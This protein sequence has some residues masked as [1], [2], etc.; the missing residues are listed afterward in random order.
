MEWPIPCSSGPISWLAAGAAVVLGQEGAAVGAPGASRRL[1]LRAEV[2]GHLLGASLVLSAAG[3]QSPR[4]ASACGP[5]EKGLL[6]ASVMLCLRRAPPGEMADLC[7]PL[8]RVMGGCL[9]G[10]GDA[11]GQK[12]VGRAAR[13]GWRRWLRSFRKWTFLTFGRWTIFP[14]FPASSYL[15][16]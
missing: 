15:F 1:C 13:C 4:A 16:L 9:D 3:Q 11:Q 6:Q 12:S 5:C 10:A 2:S 7:Q 8:L 14:K